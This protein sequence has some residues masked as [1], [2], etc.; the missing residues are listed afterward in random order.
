MKAKF[1]RNDLVTIPIALRRKAD[2]RPGDT[3]TVR[4]LKK[5]ILLIPLKPRRFRFTLTVGKVTA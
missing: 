2:I 5:K 1:Q 3:F 4:M